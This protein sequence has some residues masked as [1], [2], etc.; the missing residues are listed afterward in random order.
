[1]ASGWSN[2]LNLTI[3]G[4]YFSTQLNTYSVQVNTYTRSIIELNWSGLNKIIFTSS[5]SG[6]LDIGIDNLCIT[7]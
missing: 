2:P 6:S 5:G 7:F 4:Y 3:T 1:M